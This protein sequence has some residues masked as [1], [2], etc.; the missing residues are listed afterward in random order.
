MDEVKKTLENLFAEYSGAVV[1]QTSSAGGTNSRGSRGDGSEMFDDYESYIQSQRTN[2]ER[3]QLDLYLEETPRKLTD[4][5]DV[6][7]FWSKSS[8]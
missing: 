1:C 5:L 8:T 7:E 2:I 3:S 6:L 4:E